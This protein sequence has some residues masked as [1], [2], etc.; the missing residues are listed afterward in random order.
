MFVIVF[1]LKEFSQQTFVRVYTEKYNHLRYI[2]NDLSTLSIQLKTIPWDF[3]FVSIVLILN[4]KIRF[5]VF[6]IS[7]TFLTS[8]RGPISPQ[9]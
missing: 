4:F 3:F 7:K 1:S 2:S 6:Q 5:L 8:V 9:V